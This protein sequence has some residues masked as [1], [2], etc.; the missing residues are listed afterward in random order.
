[1]ANPELPV[2]LRAS[3]LIYQNAIH[4]VVRRVLPVTRFHVLDG[5]VG[6]FCRLLV[7]LTQICADFDD[8]C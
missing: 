5:S 3:S 7:L 2:S 6:F 1:M 4:L 8:Y